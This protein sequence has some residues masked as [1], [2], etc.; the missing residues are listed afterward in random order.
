MWVQV[1]WAGAQILVR[2]LAGWQHAAAAIELKVEDPC[3]HGNGNH[4][5]EPLSI[6]WILAVARL[7]VSERT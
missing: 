1:C 5:E 3:S 6:R 4:G 7:L 2:G